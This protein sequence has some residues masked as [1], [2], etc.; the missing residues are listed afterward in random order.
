MRLSVPISE[1]QLEPPDPVR[2]AMPIQDLTF[3]V[4][5]VEPFAPVE[6]DRVIVTVLLPGFFGLPVMSSLRAFTWRAPIPAADSAITVITKA[7]VRR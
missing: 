7:V 4:K 2:Q 1:M 6:S 5:L 3:R